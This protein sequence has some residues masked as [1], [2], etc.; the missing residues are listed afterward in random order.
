MRL[1][2]ITVTTRASVVDA[3]R[4]PRRRLVRLQRDHLGQRMADVGDRHAGLLVDL[5]LEREDHQHV[6]HRLLD[7]LD[8]PA[9]PGPDLRADEVHGRDAGRLQLHLEAEVKAGIVGADE[10]RRPFGQQAVAQVVLDA[11]DLAVA[12]DHFEQAAHGQRVHRQVGD[13]ALLGHARAA[14]AVEARFGQMRAQAG[15]Q[16]AGKHVAGHLA[17]DQRYRDVSGRCHGSRFRGTRGRPALA[18]R[19]RRRPLPARPARAL[20]SSSVRP[21]RYTVL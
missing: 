9:P 15:Q 21:E 17:G 13:E 18:A 1:P 11:L 4:A 7:F 12:R 3:E 16:A 5:F 20:A 14:D 19:C 2:G 8:A 6:R 10:H